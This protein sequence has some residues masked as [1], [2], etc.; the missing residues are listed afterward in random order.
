MTRLLGTCGVAAATMGEGLMPQAEKTARD[1]H[2][3]LEHEDQLRCTPKLAIIGASEFQNPLILAAKAR[4]IETH[5][6]AWEA[7]DVGEQTAD[8]FYPVSITEVEAIAEQCR[9]IGVDGVASIGSDLAN[10]TVAGVAEAL[11]LVA[12]SVECVARSTN[13]ELMRRT[14]AACGDPSPK[15]APVTADADLSALALTYPVIVKPAD[16]S[17]SRGITKL[18][19]P[20]GLAEAVSRAL[21]ESF[22]GEALVEEF[23]CGDEYS[24]EYLSWEGEH[25]FL[26]VTEKFTT[27]APMFIERGHLEPARIS[28]EREAAIRAVVEH[29]LDSLGVR[30]GASHS[31]VKVDADGTVKIIEIG[32]RMGGDCIGSSLVPLSRGYDFVG[33]V[34]DVA[35]GV[36]PPRPAEGPRR[37][38]AV[39]FVFSDEDE[40]VLASLQAA[41]PESV[42]FVSS[43][44]RDG[45]AIVD[46]GS[47]YGFFIFSG[48]ALEDIAEYLPEV[49]ADG[50]ASDGATTEECAR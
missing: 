29:A 8:F 38:A 40:R 39:R 25:R 17:G 37:A 4:G 45:H 41:S 24:V 27:G 23:A 3:P 14:F 9:E 32:S 10:I 47:R 22:A 43:I 31:E 13:K 50:A 26:A 35:L 30:F 48:D 33:A 28:A 36:E 7:G 16:R 49:E 1:L 46:S 44:E 2:A 11:G 12:N 15:S 34:I 18:E 5:V 42:E 19:T 6:F 21:G 20:E